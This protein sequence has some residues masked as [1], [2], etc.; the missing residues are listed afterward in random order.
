M[1]TAVYARE[2]TGRGHPGKEEMMPWLRRQL[3]GIEPN[4]ERV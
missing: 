4:P 2:S 3:E 1:I